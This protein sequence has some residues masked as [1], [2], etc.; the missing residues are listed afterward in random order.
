MK[1]DAKIRIPI[2]NHQREKNRRVMDLVG[3]QDGSIELE[4]KGSGTRSIDWSDAGPQLTEG[5]RK[6]KEMA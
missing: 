2:L 4:I 1:D 5:L 6:I 3:K